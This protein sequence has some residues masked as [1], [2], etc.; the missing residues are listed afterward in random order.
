M[1]AWYKPS[2]INHL[3]VSSFHWP[4]QD[5]QATVNLKKKNKKKTNV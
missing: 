1:D 3:Y 2:F 5:S 4:L